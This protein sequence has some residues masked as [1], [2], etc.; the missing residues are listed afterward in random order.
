MEIEELFEFVNQ[1]LKIGYSLTKVEKELNFGKDTLRKKLVRA[2]YRLDKI[3]KILIKDIEEPSKI[4]NVHKTNTNTNKD[5]EVKNK[6][7]TK[8]TTNTNSIGEDDVT[9]KNTVDYPTASDISVTKENT[10]DNINTNH[11]I[12]QNKVIK[13]N[14]NVYNIEKS[15]IEEDFSMQEQQQKINV[16]G[17]KLKDFRDMTPLEQVNL[18]NSFADGKKTLGQLTIENFAFEVDKYMLYA[19]GNYEIRYSK[20]L[21]KYVIIDLE[22]VI[23]NNN[24]YISK[25]EKEALVGLSGLDKNNLEIMVAFVKRLAAAKELFKNVDKEETEVTTVRV[26]KG[27]I[28]AFNIY[29]ENEGITKKEGYAMALMSFIKKED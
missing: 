21:K 20:G 27:V 17:I 10:V 15:I 13:T 24:D 12:E 29:C 5:K 9:K 3:N 7:V 26:Y 4:G 2:G 8:I 22:L 11:N 16:D 28:N 14:T 6:N 1:K 23:K 18:I 19:Y 25:D